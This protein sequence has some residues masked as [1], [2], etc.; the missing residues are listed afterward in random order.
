[1]KKILILFLCLLLCP[2]YVFA[3]EVPDEV[4]LYV[5]PNGN[6]QYPGSENLPFATLEKAVKTVRLLE[7]KAVV[8]L[9]QG[10]Y[11]GG[12]FLN[13]K[14][15]EVVYRAY[16]GEQ[17]IIQAESGKHTASF[18]NCGTVTVQG[19][20]FIGGTGVIISQCTGVQIFDCTFSDMTEGVQINGNARME[21]NTLTDMKGTALKATSGN[22]Q[23]LEQGTCIIVNNFISRFALSDSTKA[24]VILDGVGIAFSNNT[25]SEGQGRG[26]NVFGNQHL[27]QN[28]RIEKI[29]GDAAIGLDGNVTAR[30]TIIENNLI[31]DCPETGILLEDFSSEI[32][33]KNN[34]FCRLKEGV[35][36]L[37]GRNNEF[38]DNVSID[39][40]NSLVLEILEFPHFVKKKVQA[41][42]KQVP[43]D[44]G[45]WSSIYPALS[46]FL[47]DSPAI[48]KDNTVVGNMVFGTKETEAKEK[49]KANGT[50]EKDVILTDE[51]VFADYEGD[52]FS[53][54]K[55]DCSSVGRRNLQEFLE[56]NVVLMLESPQAVKH[57]RMTFIDS[58]NHQVMPVL[59]QDRTLVPVRFIAESMGAEVRWEA[60]T[61]KVT[62]YQEDSVISLKIGSPVITVNGEEKILDI[63]AKTKNDRTMIPLRAVAEN[64]GLSVTWEA[65]G[66]IIIGNNPVNAEDEL[67]VSSL[68][69]L[70]SVN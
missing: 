36:M 60:E 29:A 4:R 50:F 43:Y 8:T 51:S 67:L 42:L 41:D 68:R 17:V 20:S 40:E 65:S 56:E 15:T 33:V 66:I 16:P 11:E 5:A 21:G 35:R 30:G 47:K 6:D 13:E 10:T 45:I 63:P 69:R 55:W 3:Q 39:C 14:D 25:L 52:D 23:S 58:V 62:I 70:I 31:A 1:M 18:Q 9:R 12:L 61:G 22:R 54:E 44:E 57:G 46:S 27:I 24:G 53:M 7:E 26:I 37:G 28:N 64:L 48:P 49:I 2:V 34:F 32:T 38:C 19:I 59:E